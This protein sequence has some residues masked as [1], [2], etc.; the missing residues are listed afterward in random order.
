[1]SGS[2]NI[3]KNKKPDTDAYRKVVLSKRKYKIYLLVTKRFMNQSQVA[4]AQGIRRQTVNEH[5]KSLEILGLI[6]PIDRN[7]NPKFY[8]STDIVPVTSGKSGK[9]FTSVVSRSAKKVSRRVGKPYIMVKDK[10]TG[11]FKGKRKGRNGGYYRD[12]DTLVSVNGKRIPVLRLHRLAYACNILREA[13][14]KIPWKREGA[15]N[16]MQQ[17]VL[18]RRFTNAKTE[19][20]ELRKLNI[21][22][23]RQKTKRTDKIVI[24]LPQKYLFEHELEIAQKI[25]EE[26]AW[27]ARNWFVNEFKIGLSLAL[28]HC[29]MEIARELI[30]P[31][32]KQFLSKHG[33]VKIKTSRGFAIVDESQTGFP[34]KEYNTIEEM[35]A[36]LNAPDRILSLEDDMRMTTNMMRQ[37]SEMQKAM[38]ETQKN[39]MNMI[40]E[41]TQSQKSLA[42]TVSQISGIQQ[43]KNKRIDEENKERG[44]F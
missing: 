24:Y 5:V 23:V 10:K 44:M 32:M 12:Y 22:F 39:T 8:K 20:D 3:K 4:E 15:P 2:S 33:M 30:E 34:E 26:F 38:M 25:L 37:M 9:A 31:G 29:P 43:K 13:E 17:W 1:V 36:D 16:G 7:A 40:Q 18:R 35:K 21:T 42:E 27:V 28:M 19:I 11:H 6:K 41:L 14:R